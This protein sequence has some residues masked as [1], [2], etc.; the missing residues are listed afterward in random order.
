MYNVLNLEGD[1]ITVK[2]INPQ[3]H[4]HL[5][6][7]DFTEDDACV[8]TRLTELDKKEILDGI[9]TDWKELRDAWFTWKNPVDEY[10]SMEREPAVCYE[11]RQKN[12]EQAEEALKEHSITDREIAIDAYKEKYGRKPSSQMKTENIIS[13]L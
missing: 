4:K 8:K 2:T 6:G 9:D 10:L 1:R 7:R 5:S 3:I 12:I 11:A 13:K